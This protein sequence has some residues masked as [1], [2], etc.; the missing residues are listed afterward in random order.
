[1][2]TKR[3]VFL[4]VDGVCNSLG[5]SIVFKNYNVFDPISLGLLETAAAGLDLHFVLS[6]AWRTGKGLAACKNIFLS[7]GANVIAKRMLDK[8]GD[9]PGLRGNQIEA[10]L[11]RHPDIMEYVIVDDDSDMLPHQMPRFVHTNHALG[12]RLPEFVE[13]VAVFEPQHRWVRDLRR[14]LDYPQT[15]SLHGTF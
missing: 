3:I 13:L 14:V 4:D 6:S 1:M 9:E 10:W 5:S 7:R 11:S 2:T 12:F 8:T 15:R